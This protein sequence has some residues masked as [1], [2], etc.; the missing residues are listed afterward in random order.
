KLGDERLVINADHL[1]GPWRLEAKGQ[2]QR[3]N[4]IEVSDDTV[5]GG[6]G[7]MTESE[8]FNLL[9]QTASLDLLAHHARGNALRGTIGL[10]GL[11]QSNDVRGRIPLVPDAN[12]ATGGAFAFEQLTVG[13]W[14]VLSGLR[15]D[16][17]R[18]HA[19]RDS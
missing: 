14:I 4:L 5:P 10:S 11:L 3:H 6:G 19:D 16:A 15:A 12:L 8:A 2:L 9:L 1:A 7:A 17:R 18:L 13:T